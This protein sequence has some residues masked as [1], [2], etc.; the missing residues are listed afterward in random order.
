MKIFY[1]KKRKYR[2]IGNILGFKY[3]V[4]KHLKGKKFK[5]LWGLFKKIEKNYTKKYYLFGLKVFQKTDQIG[6]LLEE[7]NNIKES[8]K[9]LKIKHNMQFAI[10]K[11]HNTVFPQ[12]KNKYI[13]KDAVIVAT[14]PSLHYYKRIDNAIH[15]G[16]NSSFKIIKLDYWFAIDYSVN[17]DYIEEIKNTDF[18]KFFGQCSSSRSNHLYR[19]G[20]ETYH[21]PDTIINSCRNSFKFYFD[22]P[23]LEINRDIETEA[24]PDLGSCVFSAL[25]FAIYS[26]CKKIYLVGCDC[27]SNGYWNSKQ[28]HKR[29]NSNILKKGWRIYKEYLSIF[30]PEVEIIS[31]N[32][33]G[34][35]GFFHDIYTEEFKLTDQYKGE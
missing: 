6:I 26:G 24:F 33:I 17:R 28:P 30:Y 13:N 32:P 9:Y 5:C 4:T 15:I 16:V 21:F 12:F 20:D 23:S 11:T 35:K 25:T 1:Q 7:L 34:L 3:V 19:F 8:L 27:S 31:I 14:G 2:T 18:I 29:F 10:Q 22:H